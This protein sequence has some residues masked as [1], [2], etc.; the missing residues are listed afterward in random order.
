MKRTVSRVTATM[1]VVALAGC[2]G[3]GSS[4]NTPSTPNPSSSPSELLSTTGL[5]TDI[6]TKQ[7]DPRNLPWQPNYPLWSDGSAKE[8]WIRIPPGTRIDTSNMDRWIFP[9]GT[10]FY[11]EFSFN[12]RRIETRIMEKVG[13]AASIDSW[14]FKAFQWRA[15]ESEAVLVGPEGVPNAAPTSFGTLHDIPALEQCKACHTRGGD[16]VNAFEA[17]QLSADRDP[18]GVEA[19]KLAPG[20]VTLE[21]L[22]RQGLITNAPAQ[23]PRIHSSSA[24]GRLAMGF[25]HGNCGPCHNPQ[26]PAAQLGMEL[27]HSTT[28]RSESEEPAYRT[29]VNQLNTIF[30][31]PGTQ[32]SVNSFRILGGAPEQSAIHLRVSSRTSGQQ[33]PPFASKV[34]DQEAVNYITEWIRTLPR[35]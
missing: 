33:M 1:A 4:P 30:A 34:I 5:Y 29:T 9:V 8:R 31:L 7:V 20:D 16:A 21:D 26:G 18:I 15:D 10:K 23:Q 24:V 19:S 17:L 2:G 11:K 3:G 32:V 22:E 14:T 25:L 35:R 13:S 6:R 27:R 28:A 12:G